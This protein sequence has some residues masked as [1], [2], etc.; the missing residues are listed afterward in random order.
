[1]STE[2]T[3]QRFDYLLL[4]ADGTQECLHRTD[5]P[6]AF[7]ELQKHVGGYVTFAPVADDDNLT[8]VVNEEGLPYR[9]PP[10]ARA[11]ELAGQPIV[12][13]AVLTTKKV[14]A[15]APYEVPEEANHG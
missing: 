13:D 10:N 5:R 6:L 8:L 4:K 15:D 11:S 9:L 14:I 3:E 2:G 7:V 1:M 12:G